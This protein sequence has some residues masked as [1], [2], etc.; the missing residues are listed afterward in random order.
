MPQTL[1]WVGWGW[2]RQGRLAE[3]AVNEL[4]PKS[5]LQYFKA[6]QHGDEYAMRQGNK[7]VYIEGKWEKIFARMTWPPTTTT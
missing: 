1:S 4:I 3:G 2:V 5:D 7:N 6:R